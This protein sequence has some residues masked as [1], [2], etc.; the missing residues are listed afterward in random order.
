MQK[1]KN[2]KE[3]LK[4]APEWER[5]FYEKGSV[6]LTFFWGSDDLPTDKLINEDTFLTKYIKD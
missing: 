6:F 4:T 1:T 5:Y 2:K 3:V